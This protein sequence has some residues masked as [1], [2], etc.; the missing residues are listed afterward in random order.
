MTTI[1]PLLLEVVV[2]ATPCIPPSLV[3]DHALER[4]K[5]LAWVW[6]G[7][8]CRS[9]ALFLS[10]AQ[11]RATTH[12]SFHGRGYEK[13][14]ELVFFYLILGYEKLMEMAIRN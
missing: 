10:L 7:L 11:A 3:G 4:R 9:R 13:V 12:L 5:L 2:G 14:M 6:C 8:G 1:M